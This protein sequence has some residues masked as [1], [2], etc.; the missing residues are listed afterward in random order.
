[1]SLSAVIAQKLASFGR[2][3]RRLLLLRGLCESLVVLLTALTFTALLDW[4]FILPDALRW[5]LSGLVYLST[6]AVFWW[7]CLRPMSHIPSS[8]DLARLV[9]RAE[10]SLREDL[11]SAVELSEQSPSSQ[12]D[13][14]LFRAMVQKDVAQ[15][16]KSVD[17][18]GLLPNRLVSRRLYAA[19]GIVILCVGLALMPGSGFNQLLARALAPMANIDRVSRVKITVLEPKTSKALLPRGDNVEFLIGLTG[20]ATDKVWMETTQA[21]GT[22]ERV[23]MS[24][25]AGR[26]F[27]ATVPITSE[28]LSF[29]FRAGDAITRIF[30]LNTA[31]RPQ[32]TAYDKTYRFPTYTALPEKTVRE[33]TGDLSALEGTEAEVK[34]TS[35]QPLSRGALEIEIGNQQGQIPLQKITDTEW[36]ARVNLRAAGTYKVSLV[37]ATTG[38]ESKF[39]PQF[40]IRPVPDL[41]PRVAIESPKTDL[42]VSPEEIV[43]LKG[44]VSDDVG[45]A[46]IGQLIRVNEGPWVETALAEKSGAETNFTRRW[47]LLGLKAGP[48][49]RVTTK[50][51]ALDVRGGRGESQPLQLT[52]SSPGFDAK[53]LRAVDAR[54]AVQQALAALNKSATDLRRAWS[55]DDTKK[56]EQSSEDERKQIIVSAKS[57]A[58]ETLSQA[59]RSQNEL[60]EALPQTAAGRE[61][62]DLALVGR[63]VSLLKQDSLTQAAHELEALSRKTDTKPAKDEVRP[64][65]NAV[66]KASDIARVL[67]SAHADL[68][69]ADAAGLILGNVAYLR[70]QQQK[71]I[72]LAGSSPAQQPET[73]L[74]LSRQLGSAA[75]ETRTV[76]TLLTQLTGY[77]PTSHLDRIRRLRDG[78]QSSRTNADRSLTNTAN[79]TAPTR[80]LLTPAQNLQ[81]ATDN[82]WQQL[83]PIER[84]LAQRADK[85]REALEKIAGDV[86]DR[87]TQ[88]RKQAEEVAASEK[89]IEEQARKGKVD[90]KLAAKT[91]AQK[92]D[93]AEKWQS[94]AEQMKDTASI[95]ERR[96]DA[97]PQ[98]AEDASKTAQAL[99]AL[100]A[101][102]SGDRQAEQALP[103]MKQLEESLKSLE[104]SHRLTELTAGL[105]ELAAQ[106]K[107]E[108]KDGDAA[109]ARPRDWNFLKKELQNAPKELRDAKLPETAAQAAQKAADSAEAKAADKEMASRQDSNRTAMQQSEKLQSLANATRE[110]Q[111]QAQPQIEAARAKLSEAAPKMSEMMAGLAR[112]AEA[113]EK[114]TRTAEQQAQKA[115]EAPVKDDARSLLEKQ[116]ELTKQV[117]DLQDALRRDANVQ[118][119]AEQKGRDRSRDADDAVAML[120]EPPVRAEDALREATA[121]PD[122]KSQEKSLS[123]AATQQKKLSDALKQLS[124]HY[125]NVE[126]GR[127]D[128]TRMALRKA[129]DELGI[130][131]ALDMAYEKAEKIEE[132]AQQTPEKM[133]ADLE[134]ELSKNPLMQRELKGIADQSLDSAKASLQLAAKTE[135]DIANQL[136]NLGKGEETVASLMSQAKNLVEQAQQVADRDIPAVQAEKDAAQLPKQ[137]SLQKA[138]QAVQNSAGRVNSQTP[139]DMASALQSMTQPLRQAQRELEATADQAAKLK[140]QTAATDPKAVAAEAVQNK[141]KPVAQKA[142]EL[143]EKAEQVARQLSEQTGRRDSQMAG[144]AAMQQPV[145]EDLARA[146]SDISRAGRHEKRLGTPQGMAL[147]QVGQATEKVADTEVNAAT[148]ALRQ[149]EQPAA[150]QTAVTQAKTAVENQVKALGSALQQSAAAPQKA[151]ENSTEVPGTATPEEA[152]WKARALDQLDAMLNGSKRNAGSENGQDSK[153]QQQQA[154][155]QNGQQQ[156]KQ[157][158]AQQQ[159]GQQQNGQQQAGQQNAQSAAQQAAQQAAQAQKSQ[160]MAARNQGGTPGE[161][162]DVPGQEGEG[163]G[164]KGSFAKA[165]AGDHKA[166][167]GL[168]QMRAGDWGKLPPK[169][170]E[171]LMEARRDPLAGEYRTMVE[172]Y[173]RVIAEKARE[174]K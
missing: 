173:F 56:F 162:G 107:F 55:Y 67:E 37:S 68:L 87:L 31:S 76:E 165:K 17:V 137:D 99:A 88:L 35:T 144:A 40:E 120:R 41:V 25:V 84:E 29:R 15:R 81:K 93:L 2:R 71:N 139:A 6:A 85:A 138:Q 26:R 66:Q 23:A 62:A 53:R 9:E 75:Q 94:T 145:R 57:T 109:T 80:D 82:A 169:V 72:Q 140:S 160:M 43:N 98:F 114:D 166:L 92:K 119:I 101:A 142:R 127:G 131:S 69:S 50:L 157:D 7:R 89:R 47:D 83:Q 153:G 152:V 163:D 64:A 132:L 21:D 79:I 61:A 102:T 30:T 171:G 128:D 44:Q 123:N 11:L 32:V 22:R 158:G 36:S 16:M 46:H 34:I 48:G 117:T 91:E 126:K 134:K 51:I 70:S 129:E 14:P 49:D 110:A 168:A 96:P 5:T 151:P 73:W 54:R 115:G 63:V 38:F 108:A 3:W 111:T 58:T 113:L 95:E 105:R 161:A 10:P 97:D 112:S 124:Q 77:V 52:I 133:L 13:S 59:D 141:A 148:Q 116:Q 24:E 143:A 122:S 136:A 172:T 33:N 170:A 42:I 4:L 146:G 167:P 121:A 45:I 130:K 147:E 118:D 150:A 90:E 78:L 27:S 65:V 28:T 19:A 164:M 100:R 149:P 74:R 39:S 125:D 154:G 174:K 60:K 159:N 155:N 106:E 86:A 103:A 8:R 18:D 135:G 1:M 12:L 156:Q 20:P 104:A